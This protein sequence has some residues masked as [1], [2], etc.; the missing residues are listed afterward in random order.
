[1]SSCRLLYVGADQAESMRNE[2]VE[3][4]AELGV[5][6]VSLARLELHMDWSLTAPAA[7]SSS[8]ATRV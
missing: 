7:A 3:T 1:M 8:T 6:L 4:M 2:L 5:A